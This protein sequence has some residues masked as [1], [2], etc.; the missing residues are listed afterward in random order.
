MLLDIFIA[1]LVIIGLCCVVV[2]QDYAKE[3]NDKIDKELQE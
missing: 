3:V 2:T 1:L